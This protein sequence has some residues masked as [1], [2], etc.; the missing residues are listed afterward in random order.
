MQ[1]HTT[2]TCNVC[3]YIHMFLRLSMNYLAGRSSRST[4]ISLERWS[5]WSLN[6]ADKIIWPYLKTSRAAEFD[7]FTR[8]VYLCCWNSPLELWTENAPI[9][10]MI[11]PWPFD[12]VPSWLTWNRGRPPNQ[13]VPGRQELGHQL[14]NYTQI[15]YAYIFHP[16]SLA[17][18]KWQQV[19]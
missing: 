2:N 16:R 1:K 3:I 7:R 11:N 8:Y 10:G 9:H 15:L 6:R 14:G 18:I 12:T 5:K 19:I 17:N 13:H 4:K